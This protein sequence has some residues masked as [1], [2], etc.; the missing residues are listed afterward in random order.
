[1]GPGLD[2]HLRVHGTIFTNTK[3]NNIGEHYPYVA[4]NNYITKMP[5]RDLHIN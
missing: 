4:Q 5:T 2:S 1:M 3:M